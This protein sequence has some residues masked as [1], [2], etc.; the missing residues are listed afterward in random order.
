MAVCVVARRCYIAGCKSCGEVCLI[1]L[2]LLLSG[3]GSV[4]YVGV[5]LDEVT[6]EGGVQSL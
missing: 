2:E 3:V 5:K 6:E 4:K 1:V